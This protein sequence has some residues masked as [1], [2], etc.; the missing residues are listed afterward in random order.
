M[1]SSHH[2]SISAAG[3]TVP[4]DALIAEIVERDFAGECEFLAELVR[5]PTDNPPGNC[6][7]HAA[8]ARS[9]LEALGFVVEAHAPAAETVHAA[10]M[11]SATNLIVRQSFG[12]GGPCIALNAHGDVVPPGLGW[13][14]D[15]YGAQVI[16]DPVHGAT[17]YGRGVAVSKSDFATYTYA[18]RA[19]R[20]IAARG[21]AL[22]GTVELHLTYDEEVGGD[23]GPRWL[24]AQQLTRPDYA[25]SAGFS[26]AVTTAHNGCLHLEVTVRGR[27]GHAAMPESGVDA[28]AATTGILQAI[29]DSREQLKAHRSSVPGIVHPTINVGLIEG[30]INTNVVPD[31]VTLRIDR[32]IIPEENPEQAE[33]ELRGLIERAAGSFAGIH[34]EI[35]R[36]LL[37]LPLTRLPGA[38]RLT[39]TLQKHGE[40]IFG[41]PIAEHGVPLYTD[42]RHYTAAAIPTVLYGA[43]PR[44]LREANGHAA[45]ECLRLSDLRGA[46]ATI[47]CT[48]AEMLGQP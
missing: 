21:H 17:M 46:T 23:I 5:I 14:K 22:H 40:R 37:A 11:I 41:V 15:P 45:D 24:L 48:L 43:G 16:D 32:R 7:P 25:I 3:G 19:L 42:A 4:A 13:T 47:A 33:S 34:V 9:L 2:S 8:R 26:Y 44:T 29:Y 1:S 27:Q 20:E 39:H 12:A 31:R 36:I 6:A 35:R 38:Q 30:G 28:L 10:G 18:L